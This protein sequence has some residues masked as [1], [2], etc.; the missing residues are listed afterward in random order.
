[1]LKPRRQLLKSR[2]RAR[3]S[4]P[5]SPSNHVGRRR[6]FGAALSHLERDR[7]RSKSVTVEQDADRTQ[8]VANVLLRPAATGLGDHMALLRAEP[9]L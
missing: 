7:P 5:T 4:S 8:G 2:R 9:F 3:G 1:M 6:D